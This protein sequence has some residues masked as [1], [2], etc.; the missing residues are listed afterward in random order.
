MGALSAARSSRTQA[1]VV[2]TATMLMVLSTSLACSRTDPEGTGGA[3][4]APTSSAGAAAGSASF[5]D[6][7][8]SGCQRWVA[9]RP[10]G[11]DSNPGTEAQPWATLQHAVNRVPD[12]GCTVWI[13]DGVYPGRTDVERRFDTRTVFRGVNPYMATLQSK[14]L[15]LDVGGTSKIMFRGLQ[16]R[17]SGPG[18]IGPMIYVTGTS[19]ARADHITFLDNIFHDSYGDDLLKILNRAHNIVV[20]GNLFY[21]QADDEQHIDVNSVTNVRIQ[22][23]IFFNAFELSDRS[24]T[25]TTKHFIVV[26]D[27]DGSVDGLLGSRHITIDGNVMLNWEGGLESFVGIGNDG[28][29]YY[30]ARH[31]LIENNL[32]I[33][34]SSEELFAPLTISGAEDV[35]FV[36]NTVVGDLPSIA[37]AFHVDT[38]GSNPKN[39]NI[40]FSNNIWC[41]STGTMSDLSGGDPQHTI[42]LTLDRNLYWNAGKAIPQGSLVNIADDPGRIVRDPGLD[43]DQT[44]MVVPYWSGSGFLDSAASIRAAFVSLIQTYGNIPS[45]SPAVG[46][47]I[48]SLAPVRDILGRA[49]DRRPDLGAFEAGSGNP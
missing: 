6:A 49:R 25:K 30:E 17:Q 23:N 44:G 26:K 27:S 35:G 37:Y 1:L 13:D 47:A 41:D 24:D 20:R 16:F 5:P 2:L 29:P 34:N 48:P 4:G 43:P 28:K 10:S 11:E 12:R 32:L 36:N 46:R 40:R 33:G 3:A 21:N 38:K 8:G 14:Q 42:G 39:R 45:D 9:P 7:A 22:N 15:V 31:V 19:E 18:S